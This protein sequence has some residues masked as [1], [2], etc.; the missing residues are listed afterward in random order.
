MAAA[1]ES[2]QLPVLACAGCKKPIQFIK[3][4]EGGVE[5]DQVLRCGGCK[6]GRR[7]G[8]RLRAR[9]ATLSSAGD[10]GRVLLQR[11]LPEE[12]LGR[13][14]EGVQG[15]EGARGQEDGL[16]QGNHQGGRGS[17]RRAAPRCAAHKPLQKPLTAPRLAQ[18]GKSP[19]VGQEVVVNYTGERAHTGQG[20]AGVAQRRETLSSSA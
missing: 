3:K 18:K 20:R 4:S 16:L 2:K 14:Q 9:G 1:A 10:A 7:A 5:K 13:A 15:I 11:R 12:A 17:P 19:K 8:P 6:V